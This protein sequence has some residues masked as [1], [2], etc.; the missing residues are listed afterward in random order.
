MMSS[1]LRKF[2]D[3]DL[4]LICGLPCAGKSH[5]ANV[6]FKESGRK[7]INRKEIRR[8]LYEMMHFGEKWSEDF[9]SEA[10]EF[11]VKHVERKIIEHLLQDKRTV[12]ID[13]ASVSASSRKGYIGIAK[14]MKKSAGVVFLNV[15][16]LK[17]LQRNSKR[18]NHVPDRIVSNLSAAIDI[19]V[20]AEGFKEVLVI[21]DY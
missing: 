6:H 5:F 19:P 16:L 17:C 9:F 4:V 15:P 1:E 11:L 10:D 18:P 20:K 2:Q 8:L 21:E 14:Q 3:L 7:R 12:L 13:N